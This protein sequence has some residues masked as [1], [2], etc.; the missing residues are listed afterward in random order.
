M[1]AMTIPL[2]YNEVRW[3]ERGSARSCGAPSGQLPGRRQSGVL[4]CVKLMETL[5]VT[6]VDAGGKIAS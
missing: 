1:V 4:T 6:D 5:V 2:L 3:G